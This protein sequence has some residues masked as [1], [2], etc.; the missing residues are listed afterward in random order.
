LALEENYY[1]LDFNEEAVNSYIQEHDTGE[2][3]KEDDED[4]EGCE[5]AF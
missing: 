5:E 1:L 4:D 2:D 3:Q